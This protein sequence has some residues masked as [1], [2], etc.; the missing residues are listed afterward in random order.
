MV[1]IFDL[2][3][4]KE[5]EVYFKDIEEY[6]KKALE[7]LEISDDFDLSLIIVGK[8]KIRSINKNYRNI[9][10]VTDVISFAEI[11]SDDY[12]YLCDEVNLGDIFINVDRVNSQAKKYNHSIKREF[13]FLFVHGLLHLLGYDHMEKEDEKI[14]FAL[15]DKIVGELK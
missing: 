5:L 6:Y 11:D 2:T 3:R 1:E 10:K 15:Q 9:D 12:D 13:I 8:T 14:M 4:K 7:V